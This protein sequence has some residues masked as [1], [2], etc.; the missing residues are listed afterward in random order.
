MIFLTIINTFNTLW[1]VGM[2]IKD[3]YYK[4][5]KFWKDLTENQRSY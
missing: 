3:E 2:S 1:R 4:A 5:L